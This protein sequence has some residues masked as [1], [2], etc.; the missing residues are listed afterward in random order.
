MREL[1]TLHMPS[2]G[3]IFG[4]RQHWGDIWLVVTFL[5]HDL[6]F[7]FV[8]TQADWTILWSIYR[9]DA[10]RLGWFDCS[11]RPM[12]Q[13]NNQTLVC[14][15]EVVLDQLQVNSGVDN[16]WYEPHPHQSLQVYYLRVISCF[17]SWRMFKSDV[18]TMRR[19]DQTWSHEEQK[20]F[21]EIF[22]EE[23]ISQFRGTQEHGDQN[24]QQKIEA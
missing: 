11:Q 24:L 9:P 6:M 14:S 10:V 5:K 8:F 20:C 3:R 2:F 16:H 22:A 4:F 12:V 23:N 7:K 18:Y 17:G 15:K 21:L 13:P 19:R 1:F